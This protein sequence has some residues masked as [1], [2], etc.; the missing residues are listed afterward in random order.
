MGPLERIYAQR[1]IDY[2]SRKGE[3]IV[4]KAMR[5]KDTLNRTFNQMD[6]YGYAIWYNGVLHKSAVGDPQYGQYAEKEHKGWKDIPTAFGREWAEIFISEIP[7]TGKIPKAGFALIVFNAAFYSKI[8]E[9]GAGR[10][11]HPYRIISQVY[12][13]LEAAGKGFAGADVNK[14]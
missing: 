12:G 10:L 7:A 6:A 11:T 13:D 8:Q 14:L 2:L 1:M 3:E 5:S 9:E 4:E